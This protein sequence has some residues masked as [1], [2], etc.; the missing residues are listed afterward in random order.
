MLITYFRQR[1]KEGWS[2]QI[3]KDFNQFIKYLVNILFFTTPGEIDR[4]NVWHRNS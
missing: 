3:P 2:I 1:K 4:A